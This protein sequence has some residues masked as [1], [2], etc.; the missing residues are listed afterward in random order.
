MTILK[1]YHNF[2][3]SLI[4]FLTTMD[5]NMRNIRFEAGMQK[6]QTNCTISI[7]YWA[8]EMGIVTTPT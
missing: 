2:F 4:L 7:Q 1:Y 3:S 5:D 8:A 6:Y